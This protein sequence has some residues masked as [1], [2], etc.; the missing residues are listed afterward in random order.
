MSALLPAR[1]EKPVHLLMFSLHGQ[2]AAIPA[3][4]VREVVRSVAVAQLPKAPAIAHGVINVRGTVVPVLDVRRRFGLPPRAM[5]LA[6]QIVL[7]EAGGRTVAWCIDGAAD[8][9]EVAAEDVK[10]ARELAEGAAHVA[11]VAVLPDGVALVYD[12]ERFLS[13]SESRTLDEAL[14]AVGTAEIRES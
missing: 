12:L 6:D 14:S 1:S 7:V 10:V 2:R 4:A 11:G 13:P 5:E 9:V 8:L 3:D